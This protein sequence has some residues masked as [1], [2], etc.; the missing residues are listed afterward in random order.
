M[1]EGFPCTAHPACFHPAAKLHGL[2]ARHQRLQ[3]ARELRRS[4]SL[5]ARLIGRALQALADR[6]PEAGA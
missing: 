2:C 4:P 6:E 3:R 1:T 5:R